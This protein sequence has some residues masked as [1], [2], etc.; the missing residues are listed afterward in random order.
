MNSDCEAGFVTAFVVCIFTSLVL[1][2][3]LVIDGGYV[4]A[5]H[6]EAFNE[7]EA[8]ARAGAQAMTGSTLTGGAVA[9]EPSR[10]TEAAHAY[11]VAA[12]Q[13]G[14]VSVIGDIVEVTVTIRR[15]TVILGLGGIAETTVT[16]NARVRAVRGVMTG[17]P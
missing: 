8:A 5:A 13:T 9:A 6:R 12:G 7:A 16:G 15:R 1:L 17:E 10:A 2:A 3:G 4:L 14:S 11:L